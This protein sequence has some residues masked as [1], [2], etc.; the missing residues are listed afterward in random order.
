MEREDQVMRCIF[1]D[2]IDPF[3]A[4]APQDVVTERCSP[5]VDVSHQVGNAQIESLGFL[6]LFGHCEGKVL[7]A[8]EHLGVLVWLVIEESIVGTQ[9]LIGGTVAVGMNE[10]LPARLMN[11]VSEMK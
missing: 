2:R 3:G 10:K 8:V 4:R 5:V 11:I 6:D 7:D 1:S 9:H